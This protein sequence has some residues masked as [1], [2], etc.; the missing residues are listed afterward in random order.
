MLLQACGYHIVQKEK[1]VASS[2]QVLISKQN[3]PWQ[4]VN[5]FVSLLCEMWEDT[6]LRPY[7]KGS[8]HLCVQLSV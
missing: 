6:I 4:Q 1:P 5:V 7:F 8:S 3:F 2:T